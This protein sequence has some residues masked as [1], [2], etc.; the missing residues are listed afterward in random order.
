MFGR[1][2]TEENEVNVSKFRSQRYKKKEEN[3]VLHLFFI[4]FAT[5]TLYLLTIHEG[6]G[7]K[8]EIMDMYHIG[9][10]RCHFIGNGT[11]HHDR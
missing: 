2:V 5:R 3:F 6:R 7:G 9:M 8:Y 11:D 4:I 1:V 10:A